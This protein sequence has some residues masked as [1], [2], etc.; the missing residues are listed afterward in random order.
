MYAG[1]TTECEETNPARVCKLV[2]LTCL[3]AKHNDDDVSCAPLFVLFLG[4][5]HDRS[6]VGCLWG[7]CLSVLY[8]DTD[9]HPDNVV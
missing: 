2:Q 9:P 7:R 6:P 5:L 8:T 3:F 4:F 1:G